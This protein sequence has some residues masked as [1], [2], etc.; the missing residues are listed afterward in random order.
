MSKPAFISLL[1]RRGSKALIHRDFSSIPCICLTDE[2]YRDPQWHLDN[3]T[4]PICNKSGFLPA[5][6]EEII[7]INVKAFIQPLIGQGRRLAQSAGQLEEL[8]GNI[9]VDDHYSVFPSVWNGQTVDFS[10]WSRSG[11]DFVLYYGSNITKKFTVVASVLVPDPATGDMDH[12][13]ECALR[14][15]GS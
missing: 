9:E 3:P 15:Q 13:Y 1:K 14:L 5:S 12:H 10:N 4:Y 6:N 2:N 11:D 8:F 7:D